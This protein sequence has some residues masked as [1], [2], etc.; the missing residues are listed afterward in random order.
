MSNLLIEP[1]NADLHFHPVCALTLTEHEKKTIRASV[2]YDSIPMCISKA[3]LYS[4][5]TY[6]LSVEGRL[7]G[8][9]GVRY[10][11]VPSSGGKITG[12]PWLHATTGI[13]SVYREFIKKA[14]SVLKSMFIADCNQLTNVTWVGH[15]AA[16]RQQ[17][18]MGFE[19]EQKTYKVNGL[20]FVRYFM[21][22][23]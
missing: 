13:K 14:R 10:D 9:F 22:R 20:D 11:K 1:Y 16:I 6:V 5:K 4:S 8:V 3:L 23:E 17:L 19:F 2:G 15:T 12:I 18:M 21:I 7:V